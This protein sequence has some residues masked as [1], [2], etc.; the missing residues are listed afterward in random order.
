M[1]IGRREEQDVSI[2][3]IIMIIILLGLLL[4][5]RLSSERRKTLIS[6]KDAVP[7]TSR[8]LGQGHRDWSKDHVGQ[9]IRTGAVQ[10]LLIFKRSI[11]CHLCR[12]DDAQFLLDRRIEGNQTDKHSHTRT[13]QG[14]KE[15]RGDHVCSRNEPTNE[16][17]R[18]LENN[19]SDQCRDA[20]QW[21][22]DLMLLIVRVDVIPRTGP[23][24][25][26]D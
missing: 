14:L 24:L 25:K 20:C 11:L 10:H 23:W 19:L 2:I 3:I 9:V 1:R 22:S 26:Y 18:T 6:M 21:E 13:D 15:I 16:Q 5:I 8:C 12:T 7:A 17:R 4:L